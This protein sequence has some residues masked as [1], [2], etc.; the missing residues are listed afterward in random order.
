MQ[1]ASTDYRIP[2]NQPL[3]AGPDLRE[4]VI[5]GVFHYLLL[6]LSDMS[7]HFG[8]KVGDCPVTEEISNRL[9]CLP[10]CND[11][12]WNSLPDI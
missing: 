9:L 8:A 1:M 7:I 11:L 4:R 6:H 12:S 3:W 5:L 2:F 10:F